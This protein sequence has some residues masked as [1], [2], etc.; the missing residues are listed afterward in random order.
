MGVP[1]QSGVTVEAGE[2]ERHRPA[3]RGSPG[4]CFWGDVLGHCGRDDMQID[5]P[6]NVK[7]QFV[8]VAD[9]TWMGHSRGEGKL[10]LGL[11][12][13]GCG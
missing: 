4:P 7:F 2:R 5:T 8:L 9:T 12:S 6:M 10:L 11:A 13:R 1:D 3:P